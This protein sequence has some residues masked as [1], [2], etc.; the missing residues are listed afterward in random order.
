M[1][2]S[3]QEKRI[4]RILILLICIL[5]VGSIGLILFLH[6]KNH[7]ATASLTADIWQNGTL[8]Q[9]IPLDSVSEPYTITLTGEDGCTNVIE[10]RQGSIGIISADCPDKLCVKQGFIDSSLLPITCLPN[11]VVIQLRTNDGEEDINVY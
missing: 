4:A 2:T 6:G 5:L 1:H 9:S 11:R 8:V 7:S 10:V 3:S